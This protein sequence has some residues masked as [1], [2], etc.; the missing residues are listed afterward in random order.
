[1]DKHEL[2]RAVFLVLRCLLDAD[3]GEVPDVDPPVAR[4]G[5]EDGW[6]V[7]GPREVENLIRVALECVQLLC[8]C[9]QIVQN[10]C[11]CSDCVSERVL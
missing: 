3:L 1:M 8:G 4:G 6:V 9:A 2:R 7:R 10:D 5:G 11:L